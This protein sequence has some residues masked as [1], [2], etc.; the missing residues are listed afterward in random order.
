MSKL[1]SN[2]EQFNKSV[3]REMHKALSD[4]RNN[5]IAII[6]EHNKAAVKQRMI[7]QFFDVSQ[8]SM[9]TPSAE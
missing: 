9:V 3:Y 2:K 5:R 6:Q 8:K 1:G 4:S 7:Q